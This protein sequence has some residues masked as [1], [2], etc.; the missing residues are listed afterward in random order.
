[1]SD[2]QGDENQNTPGAEQPSKPGG[3]IQEL[4]FNIGSGAAA[5]A[6]NAPGNAPRP[7]Q[8]PAA[9]TMPE[10]P[11]IWPLEADRIAVQLPLVECLRI[12]AG[13]YGRRTSV[14]A[15]TAGLPIPKT[16]ITPILFARAAERADMHARL[17]ERSLES[18]SIAPNLPCILTLANG[19]ACIL[20]TIEYPERLPPA[21]ELGQETV[22]HPETRF[23]V[24]FPETAGGSAKHHAHGPIAALY[25]LCVFRAAGRA[26]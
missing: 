9:P 2:K 1:M 5:A 7:P 3:S 23:S 13:H 8:K 26:Q 17:V 21:R 24:E 16:G 19:A 11:G 10:M 6:Q 22:I 12:L 18:L 25:G 15:L 20:W 14:S 4:Q